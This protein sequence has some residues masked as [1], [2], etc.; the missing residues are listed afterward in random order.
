VPKNAQNSI[1]TP[2]G[3]AKIVNKSILELN[4]RLIGMAFYTP[5]FSMAIVDLIC[6][7]RKLPNMM[8]SNRW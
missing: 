1:F 2:T 3:T 6:P 4:R 7:W 5:D 8:T